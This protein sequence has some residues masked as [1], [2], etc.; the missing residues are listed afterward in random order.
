[1]KRLQILAVLFIGLLALGATCP[2]QDKEEDNSA[3]LLALML[4]SD[5]SGGCARNT[6]TCAITV[7]L[8]GGGPGTAT[9][10]VNYSTISVSSCEQELYASDNQGSH[11]VQ[12]VQWQATAGDKLTVKNFGFNPAASGAGSITVFKNGTCPH[13]TTDA[14]NA[15]GGAVTVENT[16][17]TVRTLTVTTSGTY[18]MQ[19]YTGTGL[20]GAGATI[21]KQ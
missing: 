12:Y 4:G 13:D 2:G 7:D 1:M 5:T 9:G 14:G 11:K 19:F 21:Q 20:T 18:L 16:N 3:M 15:N 6:F 10:Q 17:T 8:D